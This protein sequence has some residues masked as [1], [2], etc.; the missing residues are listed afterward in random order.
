MT[1]CPVGMWGRRRSRF[2]CGRRGAAGSSL[3]DADVQDDDG[4]AGVDARTGWSNAVD[5]RGDGV[6]VD[7]LESA[8]LLLGGGD[9]Y[10]ALNAAHMKAV[11]GRKTDARDAEWIEWASHEGD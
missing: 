4:L 3:G 6:D 11:P 7:V 8:L 10:L 9:D 1:G 2:L 5:D